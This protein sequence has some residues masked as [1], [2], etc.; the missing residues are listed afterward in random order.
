[1]LTKTALQDLEKNFKNIYELSKTN[2]STLEEIN[3]IQQKI[4]DLE[5]YFEDKTK[6]KKLEEKKKKLEEKSGALKTR[7]STIIKQRRRSHNMGT[8]VSQYK[9]T[10]SKRDSLYE[11]QGA[12]L[13]YKLPYEVQQEILEMVQTDFNSI[14][15]V[16]CAN[17]VYENLYYGIKQESEQYNRQFAETIGIKEAIDRDVLLNL[18]EIKVL[19]SNRIFPLGKRQELAKRALQECQNSEMFPKEFNEKLLQF[20]TL[21]TLDFWYLFAK[22]PNAEMVFVTEENEFQEILVPILPTIYELQ[23]NQDI[24]DNKIILRHPEYLIVGSKFN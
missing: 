7:L 13:D 12:I 23:Q 3:E 21:V 16:Q 15:E 24:Q 1:M 22:H 5:C 6:K 14:E 18:Q 20:A 8:E 11:K 9:K 19:S 4:S 10:T 2:L 17:E